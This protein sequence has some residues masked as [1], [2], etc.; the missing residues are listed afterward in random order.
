VAVSISFQHDL[1][2]AEVAYEPSPFILKIACQ[3]INEK[4]IQI[5]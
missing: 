5:K 4:N 3:E 1:M 2:I